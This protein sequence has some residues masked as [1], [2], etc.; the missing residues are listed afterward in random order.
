MRGRTRPIGR[1]P[2]MTPDMAI[3][4]L[5]TAR[6]DHL[7]DAPGGKALLDA[8]DPAQ[9]LR[10]KEVCRDLP[11]AIPRA[12]PIRRRNRASIRSARAAAPV[13]RYRE[14][15]D[16]YRAWT[17]SDDYKARMRAIA[18]APGFV[19]GQL[20]FDRKAGAHRRGR[21]QYLLGH[22]DERAG[23]RHLG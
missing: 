8:R 2:K 10:G 13:P 3:F 6:A 11:P 22:R 7:A 9:V 21:H 23:G 20:H 5:V 4:F 18:T 19:E 15:W 17:L 12:S 14:C 1:R 16:R